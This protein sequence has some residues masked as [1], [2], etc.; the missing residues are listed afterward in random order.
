MEMN[1]HFWL[2]CDISASMLNR[3]RSNH[4]INDSTCG[5]AILSDMGQQ[6]PFR[7]GTFDGCLS[8]STIQWLFYEWNGDDVFERMTTF[9]KSLL[10]CLKPNAPCVFQYYPEDEEQIGLLREAA[11]VAGFVQIES[12][13]TDKDFFPKHFFALNFLAREKRTRYLGDEAPTNILGK[14]LLGWKPDFR[15]A[16]SSDVSSINDYVKQLNSRLLNEMSFDNQDSIRPQRKWEV[17]SQFEANEIFESSEIVR[18]DIVSYTK[19]T[20]D[21]VSPFNFNDASLSYGIFIII[22]ILLFNC[23]VY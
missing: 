5:D 14:F 8:V 6:L 20:F 10:Y 21:S 3:F 19:N 15:P 22:I 11:R 13:I 23:F 1:G 2:G 17:D 4:L 18:E 12:F 7:K 16:L 9:F